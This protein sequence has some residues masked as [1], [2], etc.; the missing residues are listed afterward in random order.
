[1]HAARAIARSPAR[2]ALAWLVALAALLASGAALAQAGRVVLAVGDVAAVRGADRVRLS[3][4]ATVGVGDA[5]VTGADGHAQIRFSDEA[6]VAIKPGSEFRI[7][8]YSFA[9]RADGSER[10]VFRL[11]RGGFR[12][13]TGQIGQ[14]NRDTYQVL[15]TQATIGI[16]GTHYQLEICGP[17]ECRETPDE[18]PAAP[19]LYGGVYDGSVIAT[20]SAASAIFASREFFVVPDGGIPARLIGP[21]SFLSSRL[22][23]KQLAARSAPA[24]IGFRKVPEIPF[25]VLN[26]PWS[27]VG[28]VFSYRSPQDLTQLEPFD[29]PIVGIIGSDETT[30]EFA[31]NLGAERTQLDASG[32]LIAIDTGALVATLG[33]ASVVDT[34]SH[35]SAGAALNWGRWEGPGSTITQQLPNGTVV[36]NDGGNLHYVYGVLASDLPSAGLVEYAPVGGTRPTDSSTG[37][38]GTL[39]S[40]GRIAVNF[41]IAQ[42]TLNNLQVGFD[43]ATYT[44]SGTASLL[45]PLFSTG[46]GGGT[47]SCAGAA[48]Q[49]IVAGNFA[50]FLAGPGGTGLGLD[51]YFNTR[52]GVIEGVAGYRRCASPGNC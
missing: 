4:G 48:C 25:G 1:M 52:N 13:L 15:T 29:T 24:E 5:I 46:G 30:L 6:L 28:S 44:L 11:V 40:G 42:V 31:V 27:F 51:Y 14:V 7:E 33:T 37:E 38:V 2:L 36:R 22:V 9:G 18:P 19:G 34:G 21:P 10:A 35:P 3:A 26:P 20:T 49:P 12:T 50:G 16:R 23:G 17:G 39:L 8:A 45:G 43:N 47:T 32:R 41:T